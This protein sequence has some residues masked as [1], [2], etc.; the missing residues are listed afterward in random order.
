MIF[1]KY[2][3]E[4]ENPEKTRISTSLVLEGIF[5]EDRLKE[6]L[7]D[8]EKNARKIRVVTILCIEMNN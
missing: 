8:V 4:E 1:E 2:I 5:S 7:N 6:Y 3:N